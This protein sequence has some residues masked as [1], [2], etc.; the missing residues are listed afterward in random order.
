MSTQNSNLMC[1][2]VGLRELFPFECS[3][4]TSPDDSLS[5]EPV[6]KKNK[7]IPTCGLNQG[8]QGM[9]TAVKPTNYHR[10]VKND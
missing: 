4:S 1:G 8:L 2:L 6:L 7:N 9:K 5:P 3:G 10:M